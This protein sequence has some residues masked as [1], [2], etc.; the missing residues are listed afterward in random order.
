MT[1]GGLT[2]ALI[3][4]GIWIVLRYQ[5]N[6]DRLERERRLAVNRLGRLGDAIINDASDDA[7]YYTYTLSGVMYTA[8]QDIRSLRE[9]IPGDPSRL[10]GPTS[11]KYMTRNPAN[12]IV[13]CEQWSG[14][15]IT[16]SKELK[17][18]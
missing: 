13:V 14:L 2:L 3:V 11:L 10:I 17:Q 4:A 16:I 15:R 8:S 5:R 18:T 1:L 12:S 6:P 7:L 9:G